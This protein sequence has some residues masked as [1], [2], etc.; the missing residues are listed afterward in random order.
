M[1]GT[2][3]SEVVQNIILSHGREKLQN[4]AQRQTWLFYINFILQQLCEVGGGQV[5]SF[6]MRL[7]NKLFL[8]N[9][10]GRKCPRKDTVF[11]IKNNIHSLRNVKNWSSH[12][13]TAETNPTRNHE[14]VCSIPGL[15]QWD[16]DRHCHE[17]WCRL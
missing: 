12:C 5:S 9:L 6:H 10:S 2:K 15:T 8:L 11:E 13:G 14:V 4:S 17:L 3:R 16:K 7:G 1:F